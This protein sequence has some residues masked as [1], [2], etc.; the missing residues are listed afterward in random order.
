MNRKNDLER[1]VEKTVGGPCLNPGRALPR[2]GFQTIKWQTGAPAGAGWSKDWKH[3]KKGLRRGKTNEP[4]HPHWARNK[5]KNPIK[6]KCPSRQEP[7]RQQGKVG[8]R[9]KSLGGSVS[10]PLQEGTTFKEG[11][12]TPSARSVIGGKSPDFGGGQARVDSKA[13]QGV[14]SSA[15]NTVKH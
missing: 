2:R 7:P 1:G 6:Q 11:T 8:E 4:E 13:N 5:K 10:T 14:K 9:R 15:K 12:C 3:R